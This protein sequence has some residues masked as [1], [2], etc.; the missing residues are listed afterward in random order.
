[1]GI[2]FL[3]YKMKRVWAMDGGDNRTLCIY[4]F[5]ATKHYENTDIHFH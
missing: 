2:E 1:M 4:V 5:N 3:F